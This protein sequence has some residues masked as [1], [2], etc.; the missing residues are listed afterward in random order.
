MRNGKICLA[1]NDSVEKF[2]LAVKGLNAPLIGSVALRLADAEIVIALGFIL[3]SSTCQ[4]HQCICSSQVDAIELH[5][6]LCRKCN[7]TCQILSDQWHPMES[8]QEGPDP[9]GEEPIGLSRTDGKRRVGATLITWSHSKSMA[10]DVTILDTFAKSHIT[11]TTANAGA[12]ADK[13]VF[14][15]IS[16]YTEQSHTHRFTSFTLETEVPWNSEMVELVQEIGKRTT[17]I[18]SEPLETRNLFQ[19]ISIALQ[20]GNTLVIHNKFT[21]DHTFSSPWVPYNRK[22]I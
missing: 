22:S 18:N 10:G 4:L 1:P 8:H 15:E 2:C 13:T 11:A 16:E 20:R 9:A 19:C 5:G 17:T 3:S 21:I 12:A 14:L 6:L 7:K